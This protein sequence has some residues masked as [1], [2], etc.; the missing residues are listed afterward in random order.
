MST[1]LSLNPSRPC[2]CEK[3]SSDGRGAL[4]GCP[5]RRPTRRQAASPWRLATAR[6]AGFTVLVIA[7][8]LNCFNSR[9]ATQSAFHHLFSNFWLW[10]AVALSGALQVAVV[11]V[12]FLNVAFGTAPLT[13]H[14]WLVCLGMASVPLWYSELRKLASR[15]WHAASESH[16]NPHAVHQPHPKGQ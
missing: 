13:S 10:G 4:A 2:C 9:S 11:H 16:T 1:S 12:P 3:A 6:T 8:L 15:W 7:H 14:Q 5:I